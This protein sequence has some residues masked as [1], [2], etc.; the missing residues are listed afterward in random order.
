MRVRVRVRRLR[1]AQLRDGRG[2]VRGGGRRLPQRRQLRRRR[3]QLHLRLRRH[4]YALAL[5]ND[6]SVV[7]AAASFHNFDD[8][9]MKNDKFFYVFG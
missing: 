6:L 1:G 8:N 5:L 9:L 7:I 3:Q 4:R 2:R